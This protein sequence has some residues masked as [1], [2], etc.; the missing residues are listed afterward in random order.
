MRTL[1]LRQARSDELISK[2][3]D[4]IFLRSK[5]H[6]R[7]SVTVIVIQKVKLVAASRKI[8]NKRSN[9][10]VS[11]HLQRHKYYN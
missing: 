9:S 7:R 2:S 3:R 1:L 6:D 11:K 10:N 8:R 4:K 5:P